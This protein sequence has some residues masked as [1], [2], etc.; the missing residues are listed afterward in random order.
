MRGEG[1]TPWTERLGRREF[2]G[3]TLGAF[4]VAAVPFARRRPDAP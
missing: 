1:T 2:I 3:F 4:A